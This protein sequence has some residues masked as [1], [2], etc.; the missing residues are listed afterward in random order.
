MTR[1]AAGER[2]DRAGGAD[3]AATGE[4]QRPRGRG[5]EGALGV[6]EPEEGGVRR[7]GE[8]PDREPRR[9]QVAL[10]EDEAG[11]QPEREELAHGA[12]QQTGDDRVAGDEHHRPH[13][14]RVAG[15]E[16]EQVPGPSE[17]EVDDRGIAVLGDRHVRLGV[18]L[19][20]GGAELAPRGEAG[21]GALLPGGEHPDEQPDP[22]GREERGQDEPPERALVPHRRRTGSHPRR[23]AALTPT[24]STKARATTAGREPV[25]SP[26]VRG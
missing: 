12:H 16:G 10:G 25:A 11:E 8:R 3:P 15:K 4:E 1:V 17:P 20:E 22:A 21:R 2:R 26:V 18:P 13:Q 5:D 14:H 24:S 19:V 7:E 23:R 6:D 9:G